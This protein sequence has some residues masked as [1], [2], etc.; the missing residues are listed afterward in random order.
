[1]GLACGLIANLTGRAMF[2]V[3]N[4]L[5]DAILPRL[6]AVTSDSIAARLAE[7]H[8][9]S[10]LVLLKSIDVPPGNYLVT[11]EFLGRFSPTTDAHVDGPGTVGRADIQFP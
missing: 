4:V 3:T 2:D 7:I 6:W 9:G 1:M 5:K 10:R 11:F 8:G